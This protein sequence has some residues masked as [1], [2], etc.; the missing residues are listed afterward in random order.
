MNDEL[1][2]FLEAVFIASKPLV[3]GGEYVNIVRSVY[4]TAKKLGINPVKLS[5]VEA[6]QKYCNLKW[7]C[8]PKTVNL[9]V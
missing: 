9:A 8:V 5:R 6:W 7:S 4:R 1:K 2:K 3:Y